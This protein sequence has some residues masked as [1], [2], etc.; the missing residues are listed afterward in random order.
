MRKGSRPVGRGG[1]APTTG[2][3]DVECGHTVSFMSIVNGGCGRLV[4]ASDHD[5]LDQTLAWVGAKAGQGLLPE[6]E[7]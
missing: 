5:S 3:A 6:R 2:I 4:C 1:A 7:L